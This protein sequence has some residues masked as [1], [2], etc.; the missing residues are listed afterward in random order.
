MA[1]STVPTDALAEQVPGPGNEKPNFKLAGFGC[2][3]ILLTCVAGAGCLRACSWT[4]G[5]KVKGQAQALTVVRDTLSAWQ[6]GDD[7]SKYLVDRW[8]VPKLY[9]VS[10]FHY[11]MTR[12]IQNDDGTWDQTFTVQRMR[13]RSTNR[14]GI[15]IEKTWDF[16]VKRQQ[17][18]SWKIS[19]VRPFE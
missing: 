4:N 6:L 7:G 19:D 16:M 12:G 18:G 10:S 1:D 17:D 3:A 15:P 14:D 2:L 11:L 5:E 8:S 13:V 9:N